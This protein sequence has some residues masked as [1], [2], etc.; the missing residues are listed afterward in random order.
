[1]VLDSHMT[2]SSRDVGMVEN[3]ELLLAVLS[4]DY[5]DYARLCF[6]AYKARRFLDMA[7]NGNNLFIYDRRGRL[8]DT[9][10][11]AYFHRSR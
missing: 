3:R 10:V 2:S 6:G 7:V 4:S 8:R 9:C 5:Q 1:M 11:G